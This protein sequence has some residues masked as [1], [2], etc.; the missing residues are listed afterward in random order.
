ME[1]T[2]SPTLCIHSA[3]GRTAWAGLLSCSDPSW[4]QENEALFL[5]AG[6]VKTPKGLVIQLEELGDG[7]V[8]MPMA[9]EALLEGSPLSV[10]DRPMP[11][12]LPPAELNVRLVAHVP[13]CGRRPT[14]VVVEGGGSKVHDYLMYAGF[15]ATPSGKLYLASPKGGHSLI[16]WKCTWS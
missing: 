4:L 2:S 16:T 11:W 13:H 12:V 8:R 14:T 15:Q 5:S 10:F 6:F 3:R 1:S 7:V 9:A